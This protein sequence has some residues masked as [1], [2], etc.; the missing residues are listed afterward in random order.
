MKLQLLKAV[1]EK[2]QLLNSTS[3]KVF[4]SKLLSVISALFIIAY[5]IVIS[6]N[7]TV[8]FL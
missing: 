1:F 8:L 7:S 5:R 4:F 2:L 3:I 6:I